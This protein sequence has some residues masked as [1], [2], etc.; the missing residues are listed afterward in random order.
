MTHCNIE[1]FIF[2]NNTIFTA[3]VTNKNVVLLI[4]FLKLQMVSGQ[5]SPRKNVPRLGLRLGL[6][7][8]LEGN[9]PRGQLS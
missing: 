2:I 7:L 4:P 8:G 9:F 3:F 1:F 5:L 6:A